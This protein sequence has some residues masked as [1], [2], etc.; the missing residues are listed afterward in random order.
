MDWGSAIW[1]GILG[2][3]V[4]SVLMYMGKAMGMPMDMPRMLG[5]MVVDPS[6]GAVV[7]IGIIAHVM[8]GVLFAIVYALLFDAADIDPSWLWG[9]VLGAVHGVIAGLAMGM[10]PAMHP[11]MG[12]SKALPEPGPF[13][14]NLGAMIP[15]GIIVL[16]LVFGTVIGAVYSPA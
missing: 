6:R 9:A 7:A 11:R 2:T 4:M 5:A 1:A 10:M 12:T 8:M 15:V 14:R 16:H 13:G 3:I